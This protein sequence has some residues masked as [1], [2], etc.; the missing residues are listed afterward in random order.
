LIELLAH[1]NWADGTILAGDLGRNSETAILIEKF[2]TKYSGQVTITKDAT[3]YA[4]NLINQIIDRPD[5][6]LVLTMAQ[7][8]KLFTAAHL[9]EA[10]SFDMGIPRLVE[11]LHNL[12]LLHPL[13]FI[14]KQLDHLVV[15][16]GGEVSTSTT[17]KGN[18]DFWRVA[19][20]TKAS[21]WWLQNPGKPFEAITTSVLES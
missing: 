13:T 5:T 7:L 8:Q 14:V 4:V 6:L 2:L 20:A 9:P 18:E 11:V 17:T 16:S 12:T 21:V 3:D 1:T 10:I 15:A 19:V